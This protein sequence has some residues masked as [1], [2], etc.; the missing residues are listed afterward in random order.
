[1]KKEKTE[2]DGKKDRETIKKRKKEMKGKENRQRQKERDKDKEVIYQQ[3]YYAGKVLAVS[4]IASP[5]S[6]HLVSLS[7]FFFSSLLPLFLR[8]YHGQSCCS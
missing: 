3:E 2:K 4:T 1:M 6:L 8:Y 7:V 5:I